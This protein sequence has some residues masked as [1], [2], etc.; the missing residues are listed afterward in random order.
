MYEFNYCGNTYQ[1]EKDEADKDKYVVFS[2]AKNEDSYI[3]EWVEHN[4]SIGFDKIIIADNNDNP[5]TLPE[6]LSKYIENGTVQIFNCSGLKGFQLYI[7]DMFLHESNYKWCAYFDCDEFLELSQHKS[8]KDFLSTIKEDCVLINWIVFGG[9]GN[10]LQSEGKLEERFTE[11][12]YPAPLFKEN[13]YV[14][15][16]IRSGHTFSGFTTT[17]APTP[18]YFPS[19]SLGGYVHVDYKSH[20]YTPP[21]Y[22]YAYIRHYYSKSFEEWLNNKVKRGWPDEMPDILKAENYF[23]LE[24]PSP[25]P[26]EKYVKGLFVDNRAME[27]GKESLASMIGDSRVILVKS[28]SKNPY[29][30][31]LESFFIM[32]NFKNRVYVFEGDFIDDTLYALLL[33]YAIRTDNKAAY[34]FNDEEMGNVLE[35]YGCRNSFYWL[36]C[37]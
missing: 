17:H 1:F 16:I 36:N 8:V 4:L 10:Y 34:I 2:C 20:V 26:V 9:C 14:K 28:T 18:K 32:K 11:P 21:R 27:S 22:K 5:E 25:Y 30:I 15:P 24:N 37:L 13:Y 35:K 3:I 6:I 33:E 31:I 7:Y 23:I 12:V 29:A 19:F